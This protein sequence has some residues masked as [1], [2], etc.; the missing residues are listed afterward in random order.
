MKRLMQM[1]SWMVFVLLVSLCAL[2][3]Y[4]QDNSAKPST[5]ENQTKK[6]GKEAKTVT[7]CLQKGDEPGEFALQAEDGKVWELKSN[8]VKLEEHVGHKVSVT[9]SAREESKAEEQKEKKAGEVEKASK[10]EEYGDIRVTSLQ[11]ISA[12]CK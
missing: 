12:S 1:F 2:A 3:Q 5:Q 10:Q 7:G 9:G 6:S 11:M 8:T 4:G